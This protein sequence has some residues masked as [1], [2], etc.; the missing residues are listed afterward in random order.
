M[1]L[2]LLVG[3]VAD[4]ADEG[5]E[6]GFEGD[7]TE[8]FFVGCLHEDRVATVQP[9]QKH[10]VAHRLVGVNDEHPTDHLE[11]ARQIGGRGG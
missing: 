8:Q 5:L 10:E 1:S 11:P 3:V 4:V 6:D 9:H 2:R 7:Q